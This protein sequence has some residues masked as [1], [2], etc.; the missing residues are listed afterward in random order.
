MLASRSPSTPSPATPT[1]NTIDAVV[2]DFGN[3]LVAWDP[4]LPFKGRMSRPEWQNFA[5]A[6]DFAVMNALTDEGVSLAEVVKRVRA[7]NP[8]HGDLFDFYYQN[9]PQSLVGPIAGAAEIVREVK[10]RGFRV[11]GLTNWSAE[12]Y[13]HAPQLAPVINDLEAVVVSGQVGVAKPDPQ[14]FEL[15]ANRH[16]LLPQRTVFI[17]DSPANITTASEL[18]F[19]ALHFT[20][21]AELRADLASLGVLT[22]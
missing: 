5:R 15:T 21:T 22:S 13:H 10:A 1:T 19:H 12:T 2:F 14:I 6:S 16:Q 9:F 8:E 11:L 7:K 17:D 3:V 18:G 20:S 4:Y